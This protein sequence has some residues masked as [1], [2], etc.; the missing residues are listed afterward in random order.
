MSDVPVEQG[1]LGYNTSSERQVS[2]FCKTP[3]TYERSFGDFEGNS[4]SHLGATKP[5]WIIS[6]SA[7]WTLCHSESNIVRNSL[8]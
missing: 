1:M 2:M 4:L 3:T 5:G 8:W 6:N 7:T